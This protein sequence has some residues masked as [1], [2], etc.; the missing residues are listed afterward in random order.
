[1]LNKRHIKLLLLSRLE[2]LLAASSLGCLVGAL[3]STFFWLVGQ[4]A[5]YLWA[6]SVFLEISTANFTFHWAIAASLFAAAFAASVLARKLP[7]QRVQ[8]PADLI[9]TTQTGAPLSIR[10]GLISS[11]ITFFSLC[12]GASVGIFGP[13]VHLG[14]TIGIAV[15]NIRKKFDTQL[16]IGAGVAAAISAVFSAPLG[17]AI[18]AHEAIMRRFSTFGTTPIIASSFAG[19]LSAKVLLGDHRLLPITDPMSIRVEFIF[20]A[21]TVGLICG[22]I[23]CF[24]SIYVARSSKI[25]SLIPVSNRLRPLIPAVALL[26]ISP[27]FPHL[28]GTGLETI[29]LA[30]SGKI[31]LSLLLLLIPLKIFF[32]G[33][34]IGNGL[35]GGVFG[36]ALY[37]GVMIGAAIDYLFQVKLGVPASFC[38]VG[39]AC[40]V[41]CVVGAPLACVVIIFELTGSYEWSLLAMLGVVVSV[42]ISRSVF[43]RSIFDLQ[44]SMRGV[45]TSDDWVPNTL[46]QPSNS[47]N[48][49][50]K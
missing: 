36:P 4:C 31:S 44:L 23:S 13:L 3:S 16:F 24:Y 37:F 39:A 30:A 47:S 11:L 12:G 15:K 33:L 32:T 43:G 50:T 48:T 9:H 10:C 35:S 1:M 25:F 28:L 8:G 7:G 49:T 19:Y 22:M 17:G 29:N 20:A 21:I 41:A 40:C 45:K 26:G 18:F 42:Q 27:F 5:K 14:G 46:H 2:L 6:D 38:V 34:C